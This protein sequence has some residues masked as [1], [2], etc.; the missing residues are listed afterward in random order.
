MANTPEA[1]KQRQQF[2][3]EKSIGITDV[4]GKC[5]R[6]NGSSEDK[7]LMNIE[8]KDLKQLLIEHPQIKTLIYTSDFIKQQVNKIFNTYH[9]SSN[10]TKREYTVSIENKIYDVR[11]LY[12]PSP[13]GLRNMGKDG[14]ERRITQYKD[15]KAHV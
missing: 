2:L 8:P 6:L 5:N 3:T 14:R 1:V 15:R 11:I 7:H 12:S 4:V 13:N 10:K 9:S